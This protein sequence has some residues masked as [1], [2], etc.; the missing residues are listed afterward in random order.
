MI[1]AIA[2]RAPTELPNGGQRRTHGHGNHHEDE[3]SRS[4]QAA[5]QFVASPPSL[6]QGQSAQQGRQ[7]AQL[8]HPADRPAVLLE[9]RQRVQQ[10]VAPPVPAQCQQGIGGEQ[11]EQRM[12][13]RPR[14]RRK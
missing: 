6:R 4:G 9:Q 7:A 13:L 10:I 1:Q 8:H 11:Y 2:A 12:S 3:E 5:A 14:L